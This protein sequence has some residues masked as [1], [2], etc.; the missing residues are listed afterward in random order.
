MLKISDQVYIEIS[1]KGELKNKS[2]ILF[3]VLVIYMNLS[4]LINAK[5]E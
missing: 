5:V 2:I 4:S 1:R 3:I